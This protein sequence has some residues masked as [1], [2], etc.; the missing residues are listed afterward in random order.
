MK[1]VFYGNGTRTEVGWIWALK[2]NAKEAEM[3]TRVLL[4]HRC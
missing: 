3:V 4:V 2:S 1:L